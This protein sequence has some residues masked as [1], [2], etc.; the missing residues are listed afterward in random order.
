MPASIQH[1]PKVVRGNEESQGTLGSAL[2]S[3]GTVGVLIRF[4]SSAKTLPGVLAALRA[5]TLPPDF[6]LGVDSGSGDDSR[7]MIEAAGGSVVIWDQP[8]EHSKVLNFGLRH[9]PTV[10]VLVLS[11]HTVLDDP[12]TLARMVEV[13]R[14]P[15]SACV[16]LKWDDDPFYSD[17][18]DWTE[19]QT[20]GLKFGSIYSNS[21]GMIR[22]RLWEE[23][24]FDESLPTAEDYAW[25]LAQLK[26]GRICHRL[27]SA[28]SY[29]RGGSNRDFEFAHLVFSLSKLNRL[30]VAWLGVQG[31]LK[32]WLK[33][34]WHRDTAKSLHRS[35]LTAW[36]M[37]RWA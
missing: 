5:Q 11:S 29:Q 34:V 17:A 30:K 27:S 24:P 2:E 12:T 13:M 1:R 23:I 20:K 15:E 8:Y 4:S 7:A 22:R 28:F 31:S 10:F 9:L 14:S 19:L 35:R 33:A 25:T 37:T 18:I 16:S 21:M 6:I 3:R 26:S 32:A 36:W